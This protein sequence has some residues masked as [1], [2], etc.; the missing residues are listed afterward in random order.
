MTETK[1]LGIMNRWSLKRGAITRA[2][3]SGRFNSIYICFNVMNLP[4]ILT[5]SFCSEAHK[6]TPNPF[7]QDTRGHHTNTVECVRLEVNQLFT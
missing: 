6:T 3:R 4:P 2:D 7:S 1:N 5:C